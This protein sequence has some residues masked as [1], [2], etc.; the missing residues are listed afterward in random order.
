[1]IGVSGAS[2]RA[3][4]GACRL[5][6]HDRAGA[7]TALRDHIGDSLERD[8]HAADASLSPR[9]LAPVRRSTPRGKPG[10][11][12]RPLHQARKEHR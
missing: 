2:P 7:A 12:P 9:R 6:R 1:M 3:R 10:N 5:E 4:T 8:A 11:G